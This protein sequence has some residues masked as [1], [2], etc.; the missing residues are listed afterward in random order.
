MPVVESPPPFQR[1][2]VVTLNQ[3]RMYFLVH[4]YLHIHW[5]LGCVALNVQLFFLLFLPFLPLPGPI[6]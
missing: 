2:P 6:L 3:G 1:V 5:L 4:S